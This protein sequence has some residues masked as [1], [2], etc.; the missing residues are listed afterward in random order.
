M[1]SNCLIEALKAK[2]KNPSVKIHVYPTEINN[3]KIHFYWSDGDKYWHFI[4]Q[5]ERQFILFEG[6]LKE[7]PA[8]PFFSLMLHKMYEKK[9]SE[10][11]CIR[12]IKKY[13]LP[14]TRDDVESAYFN[15][16]MSEE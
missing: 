1:K 4:K 14:L 9:L 3:G 7:I 15:E 10:D 16:K 8:N 13:R 11:D 5:N 2:I 12:L 6:K